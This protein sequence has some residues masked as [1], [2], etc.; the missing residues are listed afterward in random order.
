M[1][2]NHLRLNVRSVGRAKGFY[3][4]FD[5]YSIEVYWEPQ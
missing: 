2:L 5:G 1:R 3:E 4:R